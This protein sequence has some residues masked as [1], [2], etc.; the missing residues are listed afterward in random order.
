MSRSKPQSE[1]FAS[2]STEDGPSKSQSSSPAKL[3]EIIFLDMTLQLGVELKL[4]IFR[5]ETEFCA[6]VI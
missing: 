4:V 1:E 6:L 3:N 5:P 2:A